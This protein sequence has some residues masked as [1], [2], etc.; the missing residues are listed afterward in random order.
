MPAKPR[1][2]TQPPVEVTV[3]AA[4]RSTRRQPRLSEKFQEVFTRNKGHGP[5]QS[6][7]KEFEAVIAPRD[8][9][10]HAA[11]DMMDADD[12]ESSDSHDEFQGVES[13]EESDSPTATR[14][15]QASTRGPAK[16]A[17]KGGKHSNKVV[18]P[19]ESLQGLGPSQPTPQLDGTPTPPHTYGSLVHRQPGECNTKGSSL[20]QY[21]YPRAESESRKRV[22]ITGPLLTKKPRTEL[23]GCRICD[24]LTDTNKEEP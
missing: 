20:W 17:S 11:P 8:D 6:P 9:G 23:V 13:S 21:L 12:T 3:V 16:G 22:A 15:R 10:Q 2:P 18:P 1:K 24:Q 7:T 4:G 5:P 14:K 19:Q